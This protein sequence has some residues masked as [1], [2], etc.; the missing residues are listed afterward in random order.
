MMN[1]GGCQRDPNS[2]YYCAWDA[3]I[4]GLVFHENGAALPIRNLAAFID[5]VKLLRNR[6]PE[7]SLC[8]MDLYVGILFRFVKQTEAYMGT[9]Q[10]DTVTMDLTWTRGNDGTTP[11]LDMDV[12]QEIE[13][14]TFDKHG[15]RPHWGKNRNAPFDGAW[16]KY[17]NLEKFLA[18]K[19]KFDPAGVFSSEWS[20]AILGIRGSVSTDAP[21]C[22]IEGNCKCSRDEH[23]A[24]LQG[25]FCRPGL[26]YPDARVCRY[27]Y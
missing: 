12:F 11:R 22:A 10:E 4:H 2:L 21:F 8:D 7:G 18:V 17:P 9:A 23:C 20:D 6:A 26:V 16:S 27:G 19:T 1:A 15:G 25:Y 14:L 24:P 5:D 13:Q 3:R